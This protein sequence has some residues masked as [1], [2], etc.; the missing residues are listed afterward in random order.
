MSHWSRILYAFALSVTLV[1]VIAVFEVLFSLDIVRLIFSDLLFVP[2]FV[3]GY[4]L[5]PY[6]NRYIKRR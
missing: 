4:L 6:L 2:I 5:A 3:I 1:C